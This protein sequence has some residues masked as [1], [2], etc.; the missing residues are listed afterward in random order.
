MLDSGN[1]PESYI[2]EYTLVY[3]DKLFPSR[4]AADIQKRG[5][6]A[7][8]KSNEDG[9]AMLVSVRDTCTFIFVY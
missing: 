6:G 8:V 3:E 5:P 1:D 7:W 9:L 2:T 4:S